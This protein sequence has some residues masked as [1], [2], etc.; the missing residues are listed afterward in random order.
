[1]NP[2]SLSVV[3]PVYNE[4]HCIQRNLEKIVRYLSSKFS[5]FEVI[6]VDDGSTDD[7]QNKLAEVARQEGRIRVISVSHN[8]GKGFAVKQGIMAAKGDM[9]VFMDA[10]LSTPIEEIE[11]AVGEL[12]RGYP[13]VVASRQHPDSIVSVH[14]SRFRERMGKCFNF[15]VRTLFR[16]PF[17]DT[18]CGFKCFSRK[19]G[20]EIFSISRVDRYA[21]D[22][23]VFLIAR[24]L[25]YEVKEIPVRWADSPMSKVS[26]IGNS[27]PVIRDLLAIYLNQFKGLYGRKS[28]Q[29]FE[30]S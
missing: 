15:L 21:F 14:Q 1:M 6:V 8:H 3:I 25:G 11:K 23:E 22:V 19:A 10:D 24:G 7:T 16:F 28:L 2:A 9:L 27:L 30:D 18:Q 29:S 17:R 5:R 20:K 12:L 4:G 26:V 13:I